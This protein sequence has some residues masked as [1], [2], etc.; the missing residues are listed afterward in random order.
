MNTN[1][2]DGDNI[3]DECEHIPKTSMKFPTKDAVYD[4]YKKYAKSVGFPVRHRTSKKDKEG[5][6]IA[7]VPECSRAG[8]KGSRSKNCLKP[9]PSMQ[10]GCLARIREKIDYAGSWVISQVF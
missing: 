7:F 2:G 1:V 10:N 6:L 9:Q 8:K 4:F 3:G 5:N